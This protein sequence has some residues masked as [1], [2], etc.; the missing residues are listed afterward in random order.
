MF[1]SHQVAPGAMIAEDF[2]S[3]KTQTPVDGQGGWFASLYGQHPAGTVVAGNDDSNRTQYLQAPG[4][5]DHYDNCKLTPELQADIRKARVI[6]ISVAHR[7]Q[8]SLSFGDFRVDFDR[9][10]SCNQANAFSITGMENEWK[11]NTWEESVFVLEKQDDGQYKARAGRRFRSGAK[12]QTFPGDAMF[13]IMPAIAPKLLALDSWASVMLRLDGNNAVDDLKIGTCDSLDELPFKIEAPKKLKPEFSPILD[14]VIPP[15]EAMDMDGIWEAVPVSAGENASPENGWRPVL[16]PASHSD[17]FSAEKSVVWFRRK[18][19]LPEKKPDAKYEVC[20]ER[21]TDRCEVFVN[22]SSA[23]ASDD[24]FFPFRIDVTPF[25]RQGTNELL[26]K[27]YGPTDATVTGKRPQ[28]L[29]F[30]YWSYEGIHFPVH[31]ETVGMVSIE[32]IFVISILTPAS[33]L[34]TRIEV[35]NHSAKPVSAQ[36]TAATQEGEFRYKPVPINLGPGETR[37]VVLKEPWNNPHLWQLHDPHLYN[38]DVAIKTGAQTIDAKRQRFGFREVRVSGPNLLVNGVKTLHRRSSG[39]S[40]RDGLMIPV[41]RKQ[42]FNGYR[43]H[44]NPSLRVA[45]ICD[46]M[47]WFLTPEGGICSP[48]SDKV[49]P[50]F[51]PAAESHLLGMMKTMRNSPSVIYW[52]L[53]NEFSSYYMQGTDEE[54]VAADARL[55]KIGK[56]MMEADPTRIYTASGDGEL[57]GQRKH[58]EA[59]ALSFHYPWQ[60]DKQHM[61]IPM[62]VDWLSKGL[63]PWQGIV[64]DKTKPVILSEDLF[65]PYGLNLPDGMTWWGG[66]SVYDPEQGVYRAWFDAIRMLAAGYYRAGV[67][68]WNIWATGEGNPVAPLY[69]FGQSMPDFLIAP[70]DLTG[71]VRANAKSVRRFDLFNKTYEAKS[72]VLTSK[73]LDKK[74]KLIQEITRNVELPAG[75]SK[76]E[77]IKLAIPDV[78]AKTDL[79]LELTLSEKEKVLARE[80]IPLTACPKIQF[81]APA[82]CVLVSANKEA[83]GEVEFAAGRFADIKSALAMRPMAMVIVSPKLGSED[84]RLLR[85]AVSGGMKAL[86]LESQPSGSLPIR[87]DAPHQAAFAFIRSPGDPAI[88]GFEESELRLWHPDMLV[89][90]RSFLKPLNQ[91]CDV[92]LDCGSGGGLKYSPLLRL[93]CGRGYYLFCQLPVVSA[94]AVEPIA[95]ALLQTLLHSLNS[96]LKS[97]GQYVAIPADS[98]DQLGAALKNAGVPFSITS[99]TG[100]EHLVMLDGK[101]PLSTKDW[102]LVAGRAANGLDTMISGMTEANAAFLSQQMGFGIHLNPSEAPQMLRKG[103]SPLS[104]GLSNGDL[105]W[106]PDGKFYETLARRTSAKVGITGLASMLDGELSAEIP[107]AESPFTPAGL[108]RV[109]FR[110]GHVILSAIRWNEYLSANPVKAR[111]TITNLLR[112]AG[113]KI[114]TEADGMAA[115]QPINLRA[116][117]NCGF[118][119]REDTKVPAW[120]GDPKDDL[121]YFPVNVTGFDPVAKMNQ[122]PEKFPGG[123][124]NYSGIDFNLIDPDTNEGRSCVIV[125][126]GGSISIPV[127]SKGDSVWMLGALGE[128]KREGTEVA[129]V[130]WTYADDTSAR[131]VLST[132]VELN[133]YQFMSPAKKGLCAWTGPTPSRKDA[134]LWCWNLVNPSPEKT[135]AAITLA[136]KDASLAIIA[137]S[138]QH[139]LN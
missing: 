80:V 85:D 79:T 123:T 113:C 56:K 11:A 30:L 31:L 52:S 60:P 6:W 131:R 65:P 10:I 132:G 8:C 139:K 70:G 39:G 40:E 111:T 50:A 114:G 35:K 105:C 72:C 5:S 73:L 93:Y 108:V 133:G 99:G 68:V 76:L 34:E 43:S 88:K 25:I 66:D 19:E 130:T 69:N 138:L 61:G 22:G 81:A 134:V 13:A 3:Y 89:S 127:D 58:G 33:S 67:S 18:F 53:S 42:G 12:D 4:G 116:L 84:A 121:R 49:E 77:E 24:G 98:T 48:H 26:V 16:V 36:V 59:P 7:G 95:P 126:A 87:A 57:G 115:Y 63:E 106:L 135:I 102:D 71:G 21:V 122:P 90:R 118:W 103:L 29:N 37:T 15:R 44:M 55:V 27:V 83:L 74:G 94:F 136:T 125:P 41:L 17:L 28:G 64:W 97:P 32:D 129:Q 91:D 128:M 104:N 117:A 38:L 107:G 100:V 82:N 124:A 120:F 75:E 119:A 62:T 86:L 51:W 9:R 54:K 1:V 109:P 45:R 137:A 23:G 78:P 110:K 112:N 46:E 92:I 96:P 101:K 2:E 20:F 47:G 14:H